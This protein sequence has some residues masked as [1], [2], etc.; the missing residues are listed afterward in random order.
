MKNK[1]KIMLIALTFL[2]LTSLHS[3]EDTYLE[4]DTYLKKCNNERN[5]L[6][7]ENEMLKADNK[8]QK[9]I[10]ESLRNRDIFKK[11]NGID[12]NIL[13]GVGFH[14]EKAIPFIGIGV[15][16]NVK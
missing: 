7:L 16:F 10:I 2:S 9:S 11:Q 4:I 1:K 6:R 8:K 12:I 5:G 3:K 13:G 14:N 15:L